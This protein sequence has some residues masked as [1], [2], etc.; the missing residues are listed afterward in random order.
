LDA[1]LAAHAPTRALRTRA[2]DAFALCVWCCAAREWLTVELFAARQRF[3]APAFQLVSSTGKTIRLEDYRGKYLVLYF[4]PKAFTPGCTHETVLFRD[5]YRELQGLG[6]EVLGVS[7]DQQ[8]VQCK[9]AD[10]YEVPFPILSDAD[11]AMCRAYAVDRRLWPVAKRVTFLIDPEGTV[12][13]R[14]TH[15]LRISAHVSDVLEA[16]RTLRAASKP[17]AAKPTAAKP[18]AITSNTKAVPKDA[19][20]R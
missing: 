7:R 20:K 4:Y 1:E 16:L 19:R 10:R 5:H 9:F 18:A 6:A 8:V 17:T 14:F 2:G 15:E 12:V 13:A 3:K 11:G